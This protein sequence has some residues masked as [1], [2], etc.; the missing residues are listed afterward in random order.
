MNEKPIEDILFDPD[1]LREVEEHH[2]RPHKR[3]PIRLDDGEDD[4]KVAVVPPEPK[5]IQS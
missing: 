2:L 5:P 4:V 3:P 1:E